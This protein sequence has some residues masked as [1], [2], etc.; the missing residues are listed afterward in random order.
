MDSS[1]P[2]IEV[3]VA[4][5]ATPPLGAAMTPPEGVSP[6]SLRLAELRSSEASH[7]SA[8]FSIMGEAPFEPSAAERSEDERSELSL[9]PAQTKAAIDHF[10]K[11][12]AAQVLHFAGTIDWTDPTQ[13]DGQE[14]SAYMT[15]FLS[16]QQTQ[17]LINAALKA[18]KGKK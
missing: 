4:A 6:V 12:S 10:V 11:A 1:N 2:H 3:Q 15:Q 14:L 13:E 8:P 9:S 16:A 5:N 18:V 17:Q 7:T